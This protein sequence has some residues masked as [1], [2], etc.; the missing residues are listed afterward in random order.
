MKRSPTLIGALFLP[1]VLETFRGVLRKRGVFCD[2]FA[3]H[4]GGVRP[5]G[6]LVDGK[7]ADGLAE[8]V[9]RGEFVEF[10]KAMSIF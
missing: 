10:V 5:L 6:L 4:R 8:R 2:S 1:G 3:S 9:G 7:M